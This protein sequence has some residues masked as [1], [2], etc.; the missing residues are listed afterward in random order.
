VS[1]TEAQV[2]LA[3]TGSLCR[4]RSGPARA[5]A[6][7]SNAMHPIHTFA[8]ALTAL[9]LALVP[10]P[11]LAQKLANEDATID[12]PTPSGSFGASI[13]LDGDR[14][15]VGR[16][17][18]NTGGIAFGEAS[19]WERQ[20]DGSWTQV[21]TLAP[22]TLQP[23][24][25]FGRGVALDGDFALVGANGDDL[26]GS[27]TGAVYAFERQNDG[28]WL[29][30]AT[31]RP[32]TPVA[33][34]GFGWTLDLEGGRA[35]IAAPNPL[36]FPFGRAAFVFERQPDGAW[37][38]RAELIN[39]D[40]AAF[41]G[42]GA[43][44]DLDGDRIAVAA[45]NQAGVAPGK[46]AV[47]LFERQTNGAWLEVER[48]TGTPTGSLGGF[49]FAL[50]LVGDEVAISSPNDRTVHVFRRIPPVGWVEVSVIQDPD[51]PFAQVFGTSLARDG[52]RL[53]VGEI[54]DLFAGGTGRIHLYEREGTNAW[55]LSV[56]LGQF[57]SLA[58][59][60]F[61]ESIDLDGDRVVGSQ[62]TAS[63]VLPAISVFELGALYHGA[64]TV[65]AASGGVH[66][67]LL[68]AGPE[69]AGDAYALLGSMSGTAPGTTD[70]VSGLT[71]PLVFDMYTDL[72][73]N[74]GGRGVL[75]PWQ[76][77]L[78]GNGA[79]DATLVVPP[80]T[81]PALVGLVLH[82][83]YFTVEF[84]PNFTVT[85]VSEPERFELVP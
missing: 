84:T 37:I 35:V 15:L 80:A 16:P 19:V 49:G 66:D 53:A 67:L 42:F 9:S 17:S 29:E 52:E 43:A 72:I 33:S 25:G 39:S 76:G 82:H 36:L 40:A 59:T 73:V 54:G 2:G 44:V 28:T 32:T 23:G 21:A 38:E 78:D 30:T 81:D 56:S 85:S 75:S 51:A 45:P 26:Q 58:N 77:V 69:R 41:D 24:D 7:H 4:V 1:P 31:L 60:T 68:R 6:V 79:A 27:N 22:T 50:A 8:L 63:T 34:D 48:L 62:T 13:D 20:S 18:A 11:A 5:L 64:P 71:L 55:R 83:A 47:H 57:T 46:G 10:V 61:A 65:S 12:A 3:S 74:T 14:L 70:P